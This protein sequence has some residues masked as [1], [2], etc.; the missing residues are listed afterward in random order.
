[1]DCPAK[2]NSVSMSWAVAEN[3]ER[4]LIGKPVWVNR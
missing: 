1:M 2:N 4:K 3:R